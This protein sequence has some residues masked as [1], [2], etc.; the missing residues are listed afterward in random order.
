[1][2]KIVLEKQ[3]L[4]VFFEKLD[5]GL[6]IYVIPKENC[7]TIYSTFSTK[8][9]SNINEFVPINQ[10]KM[11]KV[12]DG[13]AHFLEHKMFEQEDGSDP[14]S[15]FNERGCDAN[16]NTSNYKTTYLFSGTNFF[17]ENIEYLLDYVQKPY[18]TDKNVEKEK[19]IIKQEIKMYL[20][21]P[22][23]RLYEKSIYNSFSELPIK[24]PIIGDIKSINSITKDDL[25]NCYNT[26]YHPSNM[27]V[28][29]SGN[30][31]PENAIKIIK[32]N[33]DNKKFSKPFTI[34]TKKYDE[35]DEMVKVK[36][37]IKMDV[38]IPKVSVNYKIKIKKLKNIS[39]KD[40]ITYTAL[41]FDILFGAT[42]KVIENLKIDNIIN[43]NIDI[44]YL[45]TDNHI[46]FML[47]ADTNYPDKYIDTIKNNIN[48]IEI[49]EEVLERKKKTLISSLI[50]SSDNV[51]SI[52]NR[53][54]SQIIKFS[55][56]CE[57]DYNEIK[58]LN[59]KDFNIVIKELSFDNSGTVI[60]DKEK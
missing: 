54:M 50:Y 11:I 7:R 55:K 46:L 26:F 42:S 44:N 39:K 16:A 4:T 53:A 58:S 25:Y 48:N 1:M 28:V 35:P 3:D 51:F 49:D 47:M 41:Y 30:I 29:I 18:F 52:N 8:Y 36:D 5:N 40:F 19:G 32:N 15:F 13:V 9:G 27:F 37:K 6:E 12:P 43:Q 60:I 24:I 22:Y 34:K 45:D 57:N 59:I 56:I 10:K 33:Q 20:D 2:N 14:F 21:D 23:T 38:A 17:E 31:D